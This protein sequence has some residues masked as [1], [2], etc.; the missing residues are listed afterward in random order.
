MGSRVKDELS[1][2]VMGI[3]KI[4]LIDRKTG[5]IV[6]ELKSGNVLAYY[7]AY[8]FMAYF[9]SGISRGVVQYV[10]IYDSIPSRIK[11]L[12][13]SWGSRSSGSG[14]VQNTI[15]ATDSSTET[16]TAYHFSLNNVIPS[17]D[18][19]QNVVKYTPASPVSKGS[20]QILRVEWTIR[21][22]YG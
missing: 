17:D 18:L 13:G 16:Y 8:D 9:D 3:V 12:V 15:T 4:T 21:W 22:S 14:Y 11:Y 10:G 20:D 1:R 2:N 5:R 6:R 19:S 7:G